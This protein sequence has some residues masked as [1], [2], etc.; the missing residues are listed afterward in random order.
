MK[1]FL[2]SISVLMFSA[3]CLVGAKCEDNRTGLNLR[4]FDYTTGKDLLYGTSKIYNADSI[5]L[6]SLSGTDTINHYCVPGVSYSAGYDSVLWVNINVMN[7]ALVFLQLS[8]SDIDTLQLIYTVNDGGRCCGDTK[9][10]HRLRYNQDEVD[11][12]QGLLNKK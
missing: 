3:C 12:D 9:H 11:L 4:L 6:F 2:C 5:K 10:I 1:M 7:N 8:N